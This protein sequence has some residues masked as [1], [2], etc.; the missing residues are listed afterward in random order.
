M[1]LLL[2]DKIWVPE[3]S[4]EN[5]EKMQLPGFPIGIA[6]AIDLP[7]SHSHIKASTNFL[8]NRKVEPDVLARVEE[9]P[10]VVARVEEPDVPARVEEPVISLVEKPVTAR[11]EG[12][13]KLTIPRSFSNVSEKKG[14]IDTTPPIESVKEAVSR[15]GGSID[16]KARR[17]KNIQQRPKSV[18]V[19]LEI[20]QEIAELRRQ[21]KFQL[22]E[23]LYSTN[24]LIEEL[25]QY[26]ERAQREEHEAT[27]ASETA[28]LKAEELEQ[29]IVN[30]ARH[31]A[32]ISDL[33]STNEE[34]ERLHD[35]HA[36][37]VIQKD[38]AVKM[39]E[40]AVAASKK[41]E[42]SLKYL[43]FEFELLKM[44]RTSQPGAGGKDCSNWKLKLQHAEEK[45]HKLNQQASAM[46]DLKSKLDASSS[47]LLD[48][49]SEL[50]AYMKSKL[51]RE[52]DEEPK[53]VFDEVKVKTEKASAELHSVITTIRRSE[54]TVSVAVASPKAELETMSQLASAE[55]K[56]KGARGIIDLDKKLEQAEQ[57]AVYAKSLAQAAQIE[58]RE[59]KEDAEQA[60]ARASAL[61]RR[62]MAAQT[63]LEDAKYYEKVA[64]EAVKALQ[65]SESAENNYDM[66][67]PSEV[68][69]ELR[70]YYELRKRAYEADK[71]V[72]LRVV[73]ANS[74]I[75]M[76][77]DSEL[78]SLN[79]L[80]EV[81]QELAA[82]RESLKMATAKAEKAQ[83][84]KLGVEQELR[85]WKADQ[86]QKRSASLER[87][88][89]YNKSEQ[90]N[91][92]SNNTVT[93]RAP[94][95]ETKKKKKKQLFPRVIMFFSKRKARRNK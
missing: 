48:L 50:A 15:F 58:L 49:K 47:L 69:L 44:A 41:I 88:K 37:M 29:E 79:K 76:A 18:G 56:K 46:K 84:G 10:D 35:E 74:Q 26:L 36:C 7:D 25:K 53:K 73:A 77:K 54:E 78:N 14:A 71:P 81:N 65:E 4:M 40:E 66:H 39:A 8:R 6:E 59:V 2:I 82:R 23:D 20:S 45:L 86:E 80:E 62:L 61:E 9:E 24:K 1:H 67:S 83:E 12:R 52:G 42:Q 30:E 64:A 22:P 91:G 93:E 3:S 38:I 16:W 85:K 19:E 60:K 87:K 11:V 33:N 21:V 57:K 55:M 31:A 75:E 95:T 92:P 13:R 32:A 68:T 94:E 43:T 27:Q 90:I 17:A 5:V 28:R 51:K 34:L 70:E 89:E 63:E 72:D